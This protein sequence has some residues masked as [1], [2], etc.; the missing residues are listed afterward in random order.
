MEGTGG[1][2]CHS[3]AAASGAAARPVVEGKE[4]VG[5]VRDPRIR[6]PRQQLSAG[7]S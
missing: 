4:G 3:C 5:G 6:S 1:G 7:Q 2:R